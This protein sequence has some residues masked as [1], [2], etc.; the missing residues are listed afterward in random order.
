MSRMR[1]MAAAAAS[2]FAF[3]PCASAWGEAP[4]NGET[5]D[6][7]VFERPANDGSVKT[8]AI[9]LRRPGSGRI[10]IVLNPVGPAGVFQLYSA[11]DGW[12]GRQ[13]PSYKFIMPA[14]AGPLAGDI[15]DRVSKL[16]IFEFLDSGEL[17]INYVIFYDA[18]GKELGKIFRIE[19]QRKNADQFLPCR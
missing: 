5:L 9:V 13:D 4:I 17:R 12:V 14:I 1:A 15:E 10:D 19:E 18:A 8:R 2:W 7:C 3:G 11:S 16:R 6:S